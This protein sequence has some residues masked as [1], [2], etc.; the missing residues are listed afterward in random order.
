MITLNEKHWAQF[1]IG[2]LF[3]I[4]AGKQLNKRYM[5][6]GKTPFIGASDRNNGITAYISNTNCSRAENVLGVNW[7][8]SV[9]ENFYHPYEAIFSGD[10][11]I[12]KLKNRDGNKYIYLFL[13]SEILKQKEK[14]SYGY[15][16]NQTRM[17]QQKILLP[18]DNNND[19]DWQFMADY[20]KAHESKLISKYE[21]Y[22]AT[23]KLSDKQ[24][25][26]E[27]EWREFIL[28][29]IFD[30]QATN[31]GIDRNK[32]TGKSG[33]TPYITRSNNKNGLDSLIGEQEQYNLNVGNVITVGLDTQTVFYQP[34]DFYTGQNI[35]VLSNKR[36]NRYSALFLVPRIK[37]LIEKFNWGGNGAT[38]TRLKRSKI[39]LPVDSNGKLDWKYMETRERERER[40]M[41]TSVQAWLEK[42]CGENTTSEIYSTYGL[43]SN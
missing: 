8:G 38:L 18:I 11:K 1:R 26:D 5:K 6:T 14:Y 9:V 15:K 4:T 29:D 19:P 33:Q 13:K 20:M 17:K 25:F 42:L 35:Q 21:Q 3:E 10:V 23:L 16:F 39:L 27:R 22:L 24:T 31:S 28:S 37:D 2:D 43:A 12:L 34:V 7:N 32:L 30:I 36:I 41:I 40:E